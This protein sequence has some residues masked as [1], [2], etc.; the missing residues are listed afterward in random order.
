[1]GVPEHDSNGTSLQGLIEKTDTV[2]GRYVVTEWDFR[3]DVDPNYMILKDGWK[4]IIPYTSS[5]T[6]LN[7]LYDLNTDPYETT[8]LI[9]HNPERVQYKEKTEELHAYLL[10]WMK[11]NGSKHIEGVAERIL[12]SPL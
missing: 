6:V 10:E 5:S 11:K 12:I 2:H 8:N 3:G 1:M 9:G 7:G 4:L